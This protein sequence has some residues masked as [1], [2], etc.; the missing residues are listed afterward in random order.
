MHPNRSL[1]LGHVR[2]ATAFQT[3]RASKFLVYPLS[4]P[5][6]QPSQT[7][8]CIQITRCYTLLSV[9]SPSVVPDLH[10]NL[11]SI[12]CLVRTINLLIPRHAS[13][14]PVATLSCPYS[15]S[16]PALTCI[17]T[18]RC[19]L[20]MS[21]LPPPSRP[22]VHPNSSSL[23][24]LVRTVNFSL[25]SSASKLPVFTLFCLQFALYSIQKETNNYA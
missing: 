13:K 8:L 14:S 19:F 12:H 6:H 4:C 7:P 1:L 5:Y 17:Q 25:P 3:D 15:A 2:T 21:V 23:N 9:P 24:C 22:T 10:P 18:A 16:L 11:T 20:V